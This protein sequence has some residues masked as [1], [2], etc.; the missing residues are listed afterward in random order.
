[1]IRFK[2]KTINPSQPNKQVT[3]YKSFVYDP[4]AANFL[5]VTNLLNDQVISY[6]I[7]ELVVNLKLYGIWSK[8]KAIYPFVGYTS[9]SQKYN[10]KD[11]RDLD[12]AFRLSFNGGLSHSYSGVTGN[13][14]NGYY[15]THFV[16]LTNLSLLTGGGLFI[17]CGNN[18]NTGADIFGFQG[19][20]NYRYQ[21]TVRNSNTIF[22]SALGGNIDYYQS[23]NLSS[24]G[25]FGVNR[26]PND[27]TG[28]YVIENNVESFFGGGYQNPNST[29]YG[30]STVGFGF[31]SDRNHQT[32]CFTQGLNSSERNNLKTIITNFNTIN[33]SR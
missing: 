24:L 28:F 13:A 17:F 23:T 7:N 8:I 29:T 10:L 9:T 16:P 30:L 22:M 31:Y 6:S 19:G 25:F 12:I 3:Y 33:L 26:E 5:T 2:Q 32:V 15:N 21:I 1:M 18:T 27:P 14:I 20:V 4:D 11:P